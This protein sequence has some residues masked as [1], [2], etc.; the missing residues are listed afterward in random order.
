MNIPSPT[1]VL[2][3]ATGFIGSAVLAE[4]IRRQIR[5]VV[6]LRPESNRRQLPL[7]AEGKTIVA[8]K[9]DLSQVVEDLRAERPAVFIHCAWR[10]VGGEERNADFQSAE[11]VP[12]TL[13]S[14]KL[15]VA[16]GCRQWIGLGSQAEY[17]NANRILDES[18]PTLPTTQYGKAKLVAG[19]EALAMCVSAGIAGAWLRIFSTYGPGDHPHWMIPQVIRELLQGRAPQV[20]CCEQQWDYLFVAD[21]ARAIAGVAD[22]KISGIFNLGSGQARPLKQI[23]EMVRAELQTPVVPAYGAIP[24]RP[25]QVMHLQANIAK[26]HAATGWMPEVN[27]EDGIRQTVAWER[28]FLN[29]AAQ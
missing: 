28:N 17:G 27:L 9:F 26:L 23:I 11:N 18:A 4:L 8:S 2:T 10:G 3:G 1:V 5:P 7:L 24:Y 20:T 14:V 16:C 19:R 21:A 29:R 13:A 15:A 12:L 6:L 25:D 22:G